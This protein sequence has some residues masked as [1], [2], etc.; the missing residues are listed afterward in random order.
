[1][2]SLIIILT[3][4]LTLYVN[5]YAENPYKQFGCNGKE[6]LTEQERSGERTFVVVSNDSLGNFEKIVFDY[7]KS[8]Y[9]VFD[10]SDKL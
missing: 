7:N 8:Q 4:L 3:M 2:K 5:I 6:L 9:F 10:K 1:M